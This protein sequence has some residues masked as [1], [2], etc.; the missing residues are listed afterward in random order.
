MK[1]LIITVMV[2]LVLFAAEFIACT[3][4]SFVRSKN[5]EEMD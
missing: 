4:V 3:I 5:D 2:I 1:A